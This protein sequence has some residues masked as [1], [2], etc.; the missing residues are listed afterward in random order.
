M[1]VMKEFRRGAILG[2]LAF[3][4]HEE[5]KLVNPILFSGCN[6]TAIT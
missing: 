4:S 2:N 3:N 6:F 1:P 5:I